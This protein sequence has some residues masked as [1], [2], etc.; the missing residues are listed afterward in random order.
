MSTQAQAADTGTPTLPI[1]YHPKQA[2]IFFDWDVKNKVIPKGRRFGLTKGVANY[3]IEQMLDGVSPLLWVDTVN[4]NI[5]RYIERYFYPVLRHLPPSAWKWRQQKKEL[6]IFNSK[7]D[8]RSSDQPERIEGF[9]Y[10]IVFLNEAGIILRDDYLFHNV[11]QPM[12]FDFNPDMIVGGTPKGK[13]LFFE[14]AQKGEDPLKKNWGTRHFTSFDNPYLAHKEL[15]DLVEEIPEV[16]R[17]Q[18]VYAEFLEDS[19]TVFRNIKACAKAK[20]QKPK[21]GEKYYAGIDVAKH[22]DFTVIVILD[23]KGRMVF[24]DRF[25]DMDW[26]AQ[27]ERIASILNRYN[28]ALATIDSTGV[29]DPIYED[30]RRSGARVRGYKFTKES[31]KQLIESLMIS[32]EEEKVEILER[33]DPQGRV[34]FGELGIFEYEHTSSGL[35]RYNAPPGSHDDCVIALALADWML[36]HRKIPMVI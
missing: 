31:K 24:M 2:E 35:I 21:E 26:K 15:Q 13:G 14:L 18:E 12:M 10:K 25:K 23:R 9:A 29:G 28:N 7:L 32:F 19:S 11:I 8:M 16:I 17:K 6:T 34:L 4:G 5:D 27:K 36:R 30:L 20:P 22:V 33:T 1:Y 3:F